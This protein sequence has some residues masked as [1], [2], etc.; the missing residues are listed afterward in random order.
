MVNRSLR[1]FVIAGVLVSMLVG[2]DALDEW[3]ENVASNSQSGIECLPVNVSN[4]LVSDQLGTQ[5]YA[6][7]SVR[8]A[9]IRSASERTMCGVNWCQRAVY[10]LKRIEA[11]SLSKDIFD[12]QVVDDELK[13]RL[14]FQGSGTGTL[15]VEAETDDG[16]WI[17]E[18]FEIS[19][20]PVTHVDFES[21]SP[22][23]DIPIYGRCKVDDRGGEEGYV[24]FAPEEIRI[25]STITGE[26][27]KPLSGTLEGD[28]VPYEI[29]GP[30]ELRY[31]FTRYLTHETVLDV[32]ETGSGSIRS[33][34]NDSQV[35]LRVIDSLQE[36]DGWDML[37]DADQLREGYT[38]HLR[39]ALL[40]GGWPLCSSS[41][42]EDVVFESMTPDVCTA[43]PHTN[44]NGGARVTSMQPG[45]CRIEVTLAGVNG[46]AGLNTIVEK[47]VL[48]DN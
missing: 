25:E 20:E 12:A 5:V 46:G 2:C 4:Y 22:S 35:N 43:T 18:I 33:N 37:W 28:A 23:R 29:S 40:V 1:Y 36:I 47:Q 21:P 24:F 27:E 32:L 38:T 17:D 39:V 11:E 16:E 31:G 15:S 9:R 8:T 42:V 34:V 6:E 3:T 41:G 14:E 44:N 45:T 30:F 10:N 7:G 26:C 19:V 48:P 13:V